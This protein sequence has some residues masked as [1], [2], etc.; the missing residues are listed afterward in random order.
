MRVVV[1]VATSGKG[2]LDTRLGFR[3]TEKS[4]AMLRLRCCGLRVAVYRR[5]DEVVVFQIYL[6]ERGCRLWSNVWGMVN[7]A[8]A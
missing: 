4:L 3:D 1:V 2:S 5:L 7:D 6:H 8:P